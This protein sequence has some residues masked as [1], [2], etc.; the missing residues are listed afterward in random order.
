MDATK[1]PKLDRVV[2]GSVSKDTKDADNTLAKMQTLM[3]DA[4]APLVHIVESTNSGNLTI[5]TSVKAAKLALRLL[6]SASAHVSK[7]RRK[8]A[9]KDLNKELLTLVEDDERFGDVAPMLFRD[10][11]EK[12]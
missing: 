8:T 5:D 4:V 3:L 6:A 2:K 7:E 11:F 9:L 1:C 12:P 10:G